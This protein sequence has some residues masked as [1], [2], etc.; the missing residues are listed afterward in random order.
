MR[1]EACRDSKYKLITFF[2]ISYFCT[3]F[4]AQRMIHISTTFEVW[5]H[6]LHSFPKRHFKYAV[7]F[8]QSSFIHCMNMKQLSNMVAIGIVNY[9]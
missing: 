9:C 5:V 3:V 8:I 1:D 4:Q 2:R 6:N 7:S